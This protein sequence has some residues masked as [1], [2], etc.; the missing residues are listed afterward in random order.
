[1]KNDH[2]RALRGEVGGWSNGATRRN[3]RFLRSIDERKLSGVGFAVTLTLGDCPPSA[4]EFHRMRKAWSKRMER[5]GMIRMHW[6]IEWQRRGVPHLHLA[7]WFPDDRSRECAAACLSAWVDL[8]A[9]LYGS[10]PRG[11]FLRQIDGALGWFQYLSK[12]ASR[13]VKHYQRSSENLPEAWQK[14]TGRMWG[15]WGD[16]PIQPAMRFDLDNPGFH[17]FRRLVRA[18]RRA[19]A[20]ASGDRFRIRAA[21]R[22]L[23]CSEP[24]L[25][26]VRGISEWIPQDV[27]ERLL[28]N[29]VARGFEIA[30]KI[31]DQDEDSPSDDGEGS[32]LREGPGHRDS[33]P[34]QDS[35]IPVS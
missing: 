20:R 31:D 26:A 28:T 13:G 24:K 5:L 22:M 25:S 3:T 34:R 6:V 9:N 14:K 2:E 12:H 27:Q 35:S 30:T 1:M 32:R 23:D 29:I 17:A 19:D 10:S 21:R 7:I 18:W 8:T 4:V 11:Q 16:W 33:A 15:Y